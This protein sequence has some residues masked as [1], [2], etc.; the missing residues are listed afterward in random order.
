MLSSLW[1][2][3]WPAL[4][5]DEYDTLV[6]RY[7]PRV[8]K[9]N[10]EKRIDGLLKQFVTNQF[11]PRWQPLI[12]CSS[13]WDTIYDSETHTIEPQ[14]I[15]R[16]VIAHRR[17]EGFTSNALPTLIAFVRLITFMQEQVSIIEKTQQKP[18]ELPDPLKAAM[19]ETDFSNIENDVF[20]SYTKDN[21]FD[22]KRLY[23]V[24]RDKFLPLVEQKYD[25]YALWRWCL[26]KGWL[27]DEK[28]T[29]FAN[30]MSKWFPGKVQTGVAASMNDFDQGGNSY[31]HK[32]S[33][34]EYNKD[35][36]A[37][38][39][40]NFSSKDYSIIGAKRIV[41]LSK[42]LEVILKEVLL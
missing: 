15:G 17:E 19:E 32:T 24:V 34:R 1:E 28:H 13:D 10:I 30:Q 21:R 16:C 25:W 18:I 5:H 8:L 41:T 14:A 6:Q 11:E 29:S 20:T 35:E 33:P 42:Q 4:K 26:H 22:Y 40:N 36:A 2:P 9:K 12:S 37:R 3:N 31:L 39:A 23:V 38:D 27:T 7:T